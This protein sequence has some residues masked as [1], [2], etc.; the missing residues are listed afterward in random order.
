MAKI[1]KDMKLGDIVQ[2]FPES[3]SIMA[4]HG[5]HCIGCHIAAWESLE[6]GCTAHGMSDEEIES[7]LKEIN[8]GIKEHKGD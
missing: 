8:D 7:L 5:L 4:K 2:K 6:D 1:T 3:A